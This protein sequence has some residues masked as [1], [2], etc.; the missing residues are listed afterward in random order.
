MGLMFKRLIQKLTTLVKKNTPFLTGQLW[1]NC[2]QTK[3][4]T[5]DGWAKD[6]KS[7]A[8]LLHI[9]SDLYLSH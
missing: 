4:G 7:P 8:C 1:C 5:A 6:R 3:M 2:P 9:L